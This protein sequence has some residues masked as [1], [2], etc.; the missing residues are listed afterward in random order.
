[1]R[2]SAGRRVGGYQLLSVLGNGSFMTAFKARHI[3]CR[4]LCCMKAISKSASDEVRRHFETEANVLSRISHPFIADFFEDFETDRD[5][6][7]VTEYVAGRSLLELVWETGKFSERLAQRVFAQL[8]SVVAYLHEAEHIAHRDLKLENIMLDENGN[9][10]LIDFGYAAEFTQEFTELVGSPAYVAPEVAQG[11][12]YNESVD[13]WSLGVVL[14]A[15]VAGSL[16]FDG[17][18]TEVQLQKIVLMDPLMPDGISSELRDLLGRLLTK[19]PA[20]RIA[21]RGVLEHP[22]VSHANRQFTD[23]PLEMYNK[24]MELN[25]EL[26]V[27]SDIV[28]HSEISSKIGTVLKSPWQHA[29]PSKSNNENLQMAHNSNGIAAK[30]RVAQ[31]E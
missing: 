31:T 20:H 24:M 5:L 23:V 4:K 29:S 22:W 26:D 8:V 25:P 16:P 18:T 13:I 7:A 10:K 9:V 15:L 12:K 6:I 11:L 30:R 2:T 17:A 19:D 1:M 27:A 28:L 3:S 14:Y 21:I